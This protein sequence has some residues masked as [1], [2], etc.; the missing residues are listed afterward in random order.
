ML[1]RLGHAP[2]DTLF[3]D[4]SASYI[5]NASTA[6]LQTHRFTGAAEL[7]AAL[8]QLNLL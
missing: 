5:A 3:I 8:Q 1:E 7:R 4:D 6:G 2:R